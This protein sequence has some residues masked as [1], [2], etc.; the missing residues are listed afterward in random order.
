M[1]PSYHPYW[2]GECLEHR[3]DILALFKIDPNHYLTD[4]NPLELDTTEIEK[5][6]KKEYRG[7]ASK[8]HPDKANQIKDFPK[9]IIQT[10]EQLFNELTVY[11]Q[12]LIN[13]EKYNAPT[14]KEFHLLI[15]NQQGKDQ[16]II[17]NHMNLAM[18]IFYIKQE[19][20]ESLA[21]PLF[22]HFLPTFLNMYEEVKQTLTLKDQEIQK[23][24]RTY[25]MARELLG[26]ATEDRKRSTAQLT[27]SVTILDD[28]EGTL[29]GILKQ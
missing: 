6:I 8:L 10:G 16:E 17:V 5:Q 9:T 7:L 27:T 26:Q 28:L 25:E 11:Y 12:L 3:L 15:R 19:P 20:K 23:Q 18:Y 21:L 14:G 1:I 4:T 29:K 24:A 2:L 13:K 22:G